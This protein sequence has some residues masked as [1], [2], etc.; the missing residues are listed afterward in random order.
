MNVIKAALILALLTPCLSTA[1]LSV[2]DF[3]NKVT[4]E[5]TDQVGE[6]LNQWV[7]ISDTPRGKAYIFPNSISKDELGNTL[8]WVKAISDN[9]NG[10]VKTIKNLY[11]FDCDFKKSGISH[12]IGY[13]SNDEIVTE[14]SV[15]SVS[16]SLST[17]NPDSF[18]YQVMQGLCE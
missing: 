3:P 6:M 8:V 4:T 7:L 12:Y 2:N 9:F 11:V 14:Y 1:D 15:P 17:T 16:T 5:N 13:D 18:S 10:E